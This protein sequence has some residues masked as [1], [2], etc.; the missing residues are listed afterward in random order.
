MILL[1]W[2]AKELSPNARTHYLTKAKF[3]KRARATATWATLESKTK[4]MGSGLIQLNLT[5]CPPTPRNRDFDN[6]ISS[7]K[8]A[9]D[10]I[11]D[12]LKV[13]DSRFRINSIKIG[14]V[15]KPGKVLVEVL[16]L[17]A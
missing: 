13:N 9:I 2:P 15:G 4:I 10:G 11:A 7:M 1:P 8:S 16:E 5:F 17:D 6:L 3:A 12:G 14:E